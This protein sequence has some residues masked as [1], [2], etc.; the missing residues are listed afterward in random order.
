MSERSTRRLRAT[1]APPL[2]VTACLVLTA[3][4]S[5]GGVTPIQTAYNRGV[6]SYTAREYERA[7]Y[8]FRQALRNDPDDVRARFNLAL[9]LDTLARNQPPEQRR[10]TSDEAIVEYER[11][12]ET[13]PKNISA[14]INLAAI[15]FERGDT[16]RAVAELEAVIAEHPRSVAPRA[17]LANIHLRND[18]PQ[19]ARAI[20]LDAQRLDP[21]NPRLW[22]LLGQCEE[23]LG[24]NDAASRAYTAVMKTDPDDLGALLALA[25]MQLR[26]N[27]PGPAWGNARRVLFIDADNWEAQLISADAAELQGRLA[28]AA[29]HLS[30]ARDLDHQ[31]PGDVGAIDYNTRLRELYLRLAERTETDDADAAP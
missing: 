13:D 27:Q 18:D 6:A 15:A 21:A 25:R 29:F 12:L 11:V 28:A 14:R 4:F 26:L 22:F 23:M 10:A 2:I 19:T 20:V 30:R 16:G 31:R 9:S 24:D 8:E 17:A 7:I 1:A 3:C 5:S